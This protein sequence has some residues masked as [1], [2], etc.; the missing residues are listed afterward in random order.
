MQ[1]DGVDIEPVVE[2][3]GGGHSH[4]HGGG[5]PFEWGGIFELYHGETY[6]WTAQKV[7]GTYADPAMKLV[8]LEVA[9]A[10]EAGFHAAEESV[11]ALM[12]GECTAVVAG[13]DIVPG[14]TCYSLEFD[15]DVYST[16]YRVPVPSRRRLSEG[17]H[18]DHG[19]FA[20]YAEH[21]PTEFELDSH[22]LKDDHGDDIEPLFEEPGEAGSAG[23]RRGYAWRN[24][25]IATFVVLMCTFVG[26]LSRLGL[27]DAIVRAQY[28]IPF[29]SAMGAGALLGCSV[30]L[31]FVEGT[32]LIA[33]RWPKEVDATWRWGTA[34]LGGYLL[35][36]VTELMFPRAAKATP[37][38]AAVETKALVP[39]EKI[40]EEAVG[41][42]KLEPVIQAEPDIAFAFNIFFGD[43]W[44]GDRRRT[45]RVSTT[46]PRRPPRASAA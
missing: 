44:R 14:S 7:D 11:E 25:M 28:I 29:A 27:K 45:T 41:A 5:G 18:G 9:S 1:Q 16:V 37:A 2:E 33:A 8:V 36:L 3:G 31:M 43:F 12:D 15:A 30:F 34:V 32:H 20:F 10:D 22:Y 38:A 26:A 40:D 13:G 39:A 46:E 21:M 42:A 4:G 23:T 19:F 35:G 17:D 24:S 6:A